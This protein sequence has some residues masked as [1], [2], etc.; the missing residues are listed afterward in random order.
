MVVFDAVNRV[1]EWWSEKVTEPTDKLNDELIYQHKDMHYSRHK[2]TELIGGKKVVWLTTDSN[3]SF[4]HNKKEW[5]GTTICFDV[6]E[7][8]GKT[9]LRFTHLGLTPKC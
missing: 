5:T 2:I 8:D 6:S 1:N 9:H 7:K 3:L 4:I